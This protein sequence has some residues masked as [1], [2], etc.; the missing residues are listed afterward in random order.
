[1]NT[2]TKSSIGAII[3]ALLG[4][5]CLIFH[6]QS[7]VSPTPP[8][9]GPVV[10]TIV[11]HDTVWLVKGIPVNHFDTLRK[12]DTLKVVVFPIV[13]SG[14]H[15]ETLSIADRPVIVR[16][17]EDSTGNMIVFAG[18][19]NEGKF[20]AYAFKGVKPPYQLYLR[21]DGSPVCE[22][23]SKGK[24][25]RVSA[26]KLGLYGGV[27]YAVDHTTLTKFNWSNF[28]PTLMGEA[29]YG[30]FVVRVGAG[31]SKAKAAI[32]RAAFIKLQEL[33]RERGEPEPESF[34]DWQ[35]AADVKPL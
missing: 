19:S 25:K 5:A 28:Y 8:A 30:H 12:V 34:P 10:D 9:T 14:G 4:L 26:I 13:D 23:T 16:V 33:A 20:A 22:Y 6:I 1:M 7:P 11:Q 24:T 27:G 15:H 32:D 21:A 29:Q 35:F 18:M 2:Q 3:V 31:W 17:I